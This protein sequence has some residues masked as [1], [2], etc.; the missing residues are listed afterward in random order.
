M[1]GAG[2]PVTLINLPALPH[3]GR[4]PSWPGRVHPGGAESG[5]STPHPAVLPGGRLRTQEARAVAAGTERT[6]HTPRSVGRPGRLL[7]LCGCA[8]PLLAYALVWSAIGQLSVSGGW[9]QIGWIHPLP[10]APGRG[11]GRDDRWH[12]LRAR[13]V[14]THLE[15]RPR[16][17]R[18]A[19]ADTDRAG[20][21]VRRMDGLRRTRRLKPSVPT[22]VAAC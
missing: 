6:D 15:R 20:Y 1:Q 2:Q 17:A 8:L 19:V 11:R 16:P 12:P 4:G 9:R 18:Q 3:P 14:H 5:S 10:A 22:S 7:V 21:R 13:L